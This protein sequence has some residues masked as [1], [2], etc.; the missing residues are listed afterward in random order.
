MNALALALDNKKAD[1]ETMILGS[2][3]ETSINQ[4][5]ST[6]S[7]IVGVDLKP[8]YEPK[9]LGDIRQMRYNCQKAQRILGWKATTTLEQGVREIVE[10]QK[11]GTGASIKS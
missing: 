6:V 4:L 2:G 1:G 9:K 3:R 7:K 10:Y 11:A 8:K 5:Y